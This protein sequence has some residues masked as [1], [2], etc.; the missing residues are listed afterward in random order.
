[1]DSCL[2]NK[3]MEILRKICMMGC[4]VGCVAPGMAQQ[5]NTLRGTIEDA[6]TE[7]PLGFATIQL[8]HQNE[9]S[10]AAVADYNGYYSFSKLPSGS[11]R[12]E[13]SYL[14]YDK[15]I[16]TLFIS[17]D[18]E[19]DIRLKSTVCSLNEVVV[20]ASEQKGFTSSSRIDRTAM[21]HLQPSSF[22][23][24]LELLPGGKSVDPNMGN[25]NTIRLR[26]AGS[27][28]EDIASL[29]VAFVMDGMPLNENANLQYVPGTYH[30]GKEFVSKGVD[31]RMISTDNIE[32]VEIV[33]GIPSVEYGDLTGGLVN[34]KRKWSV[35][36]L[37]ARFK[38]DS[39]SKLFSAGKGWTIDGKHILNIDLGY[40]DSKMD[41]RDSREN[42]KRISASVRW[43]A[44]YKTFFGHVDWNMH[45]DY[46]GSFDNVKVDKD[47]TVKE[48]SYKSSYNK[49]AV[50]ATWSLK[51]T[52]S[53]FRRLVAHV[54]VSQ[55]YNRI[56]EHRSVSI[57]RPTAIPHSLTEGEAD[58]TYL[59]YTYVA[60]MLVDGKP[61][62]ANA[63]LLGDFVFHIWNFSHT[64]RGG[65]E[66]NFSKNYGDGSVYDMNRPLNVASVYRPRRYKDIPGRQDFSLFVE[67]QWRMALGKHELALSAG[68]RANALVGL[69][70]TYAMSGKFYLDPRVNLQW[71]LPSLGVNEDWL[72]DLT[73]GIGWLSKLPTT[74]QLYPDYKY[75]DI[76]QLNFYH[77]NPHYHRVNLMTY[78]WDN[79]NYDLKPSCNRKWE[80]RL[81]ISYK[82]NNMSVTYFQERMNDA[83]R[84][85]SYYRIFSYKNYDVSGLNV[86]EL[87]APPSLENLPYTDK[88]VINTYSKVGNG[89][90]VRK[91]GVEFAFS[92]KR[93]DWLKT[94]FTVTGAYFK[95]TYS[96]NLPEYKTSSVLI[97][98]EQLKYVGLYDWEEGTARESFN[99][100]FVSDTYLPKI[101]MVFSLSAQCTW[102]TASRPLWNNGTPVSYVDNQGNVYPFTE[103][104]A[105]NMELQHLV[106]TYSLSYFDKTRV[107]FAM[108]IN[109]KATKEVGKFLKVSLFV[110]RILTAYPSYYRGTT[111]IR[112]SSS[113]YF[114][115]EANLRF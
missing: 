108:D 8:R 14:G 112:C 51:R 53:L 69:S 21:E 75:V 41:P 102:F 2:Q 91:Q 81:G 40:L 18:E 5:W 44:D 64:L 74:A 19:L 85:I 84:D 43:A 63:K 60:N 28:D 25:A 77:N 38:A 15:D 52:E 37:T 33:R 113:P 58:G 10:Y 86:S 98:N 73:T 24:L 31:M 11:Y 45:A 23:D 32:S 82:G 96:N 106:Q 50:G 42:Y 107:P 68:L 87:T 114:G 61:L 13:V 79:T 30:G 49:F 47:V 99:T 34:I 72:V 22:T 115:M 89:T 83:F 6:N 65:V 39:G 9:T 4:L 26:E 36:P 70:D 104:S 109:L 71:K 93:I 80:L 27:T 111:L 110:N 78:K 59:P 3:N 57:D 105:S 29:G 97:Q 1:M 12:V 67:E 17:Q 16:R 66:W 88:S 35:S 76:V 20:T 90:R 101:G 46:T 62:Y 100:H 54:S 55:E 94:R 48:N 95:T 7:E 103:E 56:K 92:S